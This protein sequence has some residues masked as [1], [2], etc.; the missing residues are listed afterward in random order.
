MRTLEI[1]GILFVA[2]G[3]IITKMPAFL[4]AI[5]VTSVYELEMY[6]KCS[7]SES[8]GLWYTISYVN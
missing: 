4:T 6:W 8:V 7:G 3:T 5:V 1:S 2:A